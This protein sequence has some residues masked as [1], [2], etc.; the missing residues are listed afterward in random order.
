MSRSHAVLVA[1]LLGLAGLVGLSRLVSATDDPTETS[2]SPSGDSTPPAVGLDPPSP[3]GERPSAP[4][5]DDVRAAQGLAP[6]SVTEPGCALSVELRN[7]DRHPEVACLESQLVEAGILDVP[8]PDDVFDDATASAVRSFQERSRL[9]VDGVVGPLTRKELK[10]AVGADPLPP[11]P[12]TCPSGGRAAVVDRYHQRTWLCEDRAITQLMPMTSAL[13]QPDPGTYSVYAK[14]LRSS[15]ETSK[16]YS[17]MTHFVAF[18][19]GK[20]QGDR[21]AFHSVPRYRSGEF[22]QP[23]DSVGTTELHGDS[24]GCI[25]VL[26]DDAELIWEWLDV[27]DTVVV[28]T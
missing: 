1:A 15:S 3:V 10:L 28:V 17:E 21:I 6:V 14:D 16:G 27:G 20:Y 23:L 22:V 18:S 11:D 26:P 7:G 9:P 5:A 13:S 19:H 8:S 24:A 25:R 4:L 12:A 2:S